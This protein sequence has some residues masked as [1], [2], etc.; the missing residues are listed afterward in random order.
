MRGKVSNIF[1]GILF[2]LAGGA[3]L[4]DRM[5]WI[6]FS[7]FS[8]DTWVYL[9]GAAGVVF[10]IGY[11]LSGFRK[12]GLLFPALIL[13]AIGLTIWMGD[14]GITASY[15]GVPVL[16]AI[17]IPF[18]VGFL[19]DRKAWGLLI[20]AWVLTFS[21]LAALLGD[22]VPGTLIGSLVLY[23][24]AAPF[25]VAYLMD[26]TRWWALIPAWVMFLIGTITL[27]SDHV[28]G[29]LIGALV[30]YGIALP[31]LV[32]YLSDRSRRWALIPAGVMGV[33]GTLP[34]IAGVTSGDWTGV[35]VMLLFSA[36][37]FFVYF[38]FGRKFTWWALIPAGVF[39]S[40]AL[41]VLLSILLPQENTFVQGVLTGVLLLGFG[42]TFGA[43]WLLRKVHPTAWASYPA[44]GL[45]VAGVLA[46]VFG[47]N[48]NLFW[49]IA[50]LAAG[51]V[52][53]VY[54]FLRN[55]TAV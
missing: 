37:F 9:F 33:I 30:L 24:I 16:L 12:W 26:R 6:N 25:L 47:G 14:R 10:L 21:A 11:F 32:V 34:L 49:A 5:G 17:A 20:P 48:S 54:S 39:A 15:V 23:S 28:N 44:L 7:L 41:V 2:I 46:F 38:Y 36:V 42:A 43:L 40:I 52:L 18:Y 31:F 53:V 35:V 55:R 27:I 22:R 29:N 51:V 13:G 8:N 1:W 50:L 45:L 4:A 3:L 19:L